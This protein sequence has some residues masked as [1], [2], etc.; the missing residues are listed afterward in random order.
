VCS[1]YRK[2]SGFFLWFFVLKVGKDLY[3]S[4]AKPP[5]RRYYFGIESENF[6][7]DY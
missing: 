3:K 1:R 5:K 4:L 7:R 6:L 2:D